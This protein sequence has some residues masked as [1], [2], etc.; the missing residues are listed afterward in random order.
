MRG[1]NKSDYKSEYQITNDQ[2]RGRRENISEKED[3]NK[4]GGKGEYPSMICNVNG[5]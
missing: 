4:M 1:S 3:G 2:E 5:M